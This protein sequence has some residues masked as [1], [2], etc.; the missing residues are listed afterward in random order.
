MLS[1]D[2]QAE[3][4][5]DLIVQELDALICNIYPPT[6]LAR[7]L[8]SGIPII[9]VAEIP[10]RHPRFT[11][12]LGLYDAGYM[13][14]TFLHERLAGS[15]TVLVVGGYMAVE[16]DNGQ[17]RLDGFFAALPSDHHYAIH[18]VQS[19][20][21]QEDAIHE[22]TAYLG[23]HANLQVN[24][25]FGLSD[26]IAIAAR[27]VCQSLG[28]IDNDTLILG[29]NGDPLAL[30]S[31]ADGRM[32]ATIETDIDDLATQVVDLAYHAA[33]GD[34]LPPYFRN[35]QRLVTADN[36]AEVATRKL[37]SLAT[38]PTRLVD[39]NRRNAQERIMQRET[40]LEIDR[41]VGLILD[42]Q[43]LSLAITALIRD[44]Y[45]FDDARFLVWNQH[46]ARLVEIG[47]VR[48]ADKGANM[49]I[50]PSGPLEYALTHNQ[51]VF[52]PD[53]YG[54]SRFA[55]DP[56]WPEMHARVVVPVHLGG[57]IVG[58]LDL[59][60][61]AVTHY[62]R[63]ELDGLELLA[64]RLGISIRNAEL[65]GEALDAR[66]IAEKADRLKTVLLTNVS[67]ELRTPLNVILGYS[68]A[69]LDT[70]AALARHMT[71]SSA[72][73]VTHIYS[74]AEHLLRLI[75]D[76]LDLSRAE[77][78]ELDLLPE[79]LNTRS[80]LEEV[81]RGQHHALRRRW[82]GGLA[83][84]SAAGASIARSRSGAPAA[85][86]AQL[87]A[88]R[89]QIHRARPDHARRRGSAARSAYLGRR[90]RGGHPRRVAGA[91][92][93]ALH[94]RR[95]Q[96]AAA[97]GDRPWTQYRAAA[98]RAAPRPDDAGEPAWSRQHLPYLS[99]AASLGDYSGSAERWRPAGA[100]ADHRGHNAADER[101]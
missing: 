77:I 88:Q 3:V 5:E 91:N 11:S 34:P 15:G 80:F 51:T 86:A 47:D 90:H 68:R 7:I 60:R 82:C 62:T 6:L 41:Q 76:L 19:K 75:N 17:S 84:G 14:G 10:L 64:D 18:H 32:T 30:A 100:A 79:T 63:E 28:C 24:A 69:T 39:V 99:A 73:D 94:Q 20:W 16:E 98:G 1:S 61:R 22:L 53:T 23:E 85:G 9:Y 96:R 36:V 67:H 81:F 2:V 83:L 52:I 46:D 54:S 48:R 89:P 50:A 29:I 56:L 78:D 12:R 40:S 13:L 43:Q 25:I 4:V 21:P 55:P 33:C 66:S 45:G 57:R 35:R 65:Y 8:D 74:S 37:L 31:I 58:L 101:G 70:L 93:R 49:G 59:H 92:L 44:N 95:H 26:M 71:P 42:E 87:A 27:D 97:R 72:Q 38:L